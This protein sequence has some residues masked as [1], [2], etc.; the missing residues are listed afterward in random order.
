MRILTLSSLYPNAVKPHHGVFVETRLRSIRDLGGLE[1]RVL[2]PVPWF[3]SRARIFGAYADLARIPRRDARHGIAVAYPRYPVIPKLGMSLQA[4][5]MARWLRPVVERSIAAEGDIDLIDAHYA[6]PDGVAAARLAR[7]LGKP[8][9]ITA[10]GSDIN[11]I[12]RHPGPR[13]MIRE[14]AGQAAT[15]IAV[16]EALRQEMIAMGIEAGKI[17]TLRNGVDLARFR[18]VEGEAFRAAQ[19]LTGPLLLSVGNLVPLK[20]HDQVIRALSRLPEATLAIV[21]SGPGAASLRA[22]AAE[23]GLAS[24]VRLLGAL[25][26]DALAAAYSAADLLV[27]ASSSE[28]WPNVLLEAMACGTPVLASDRGGVPEIV[29][30]PEVGRLMAEPSPDAIAREAAA[31]LAAPPAP[32][33]LR[34]HAESF[35]WGETA[36]RQHALYREICAAAPRP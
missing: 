31:L 5:L 24:R 9:V 34:R 26:H 36:A 18:P 27:L 33:V 19:Q 29:S 14:A 35:G 1:A 16:S 32:A 3:P 2:A 25:P 10:R 4:G 6:Y 23:L 30:R 17:E 15:V 8:L 28:G 7:Q 11:V 20:G 12:A 21:G 22:L 13:R